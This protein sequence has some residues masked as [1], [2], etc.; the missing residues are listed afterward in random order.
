MREEDRYLQ[1]RGG[2]WHYVR[3]VPIDVAHHYSDASCTIRKSLKTDD[4]AEAR[5]RRDALEE[6][7]NA[8]WVSLRLDGKASDATERRYEAAVK[9]A[10]A[11]S[12]RY[13]P[14]SDLLPGA[15]INQLIERLKVI[16]GEK[17]AE[18]AVNTALLG[19]LDRPPVTLQDA[20]QVI[21]DE[22]H[23][24]YLNA[25]DEEGRTDWL[26]GKQRSID[27]F[28]SLYGDKPIDEIDRE[29]AR[30]FFN[31]WKERITKGDET[32]TGGYANRHIGNLRKLLSDYWAH[33]GED[34]ENPF[35]GFSFLNKR[36]SKRRPFSEE[37]IKALFLK[38][39]KFCDLNREARF[40]ILMMVETGARLSE[41]ATLRKQD[42]ILDHDYPHV[43]IE[44][45]DGRSVKTDNSNRIMPLVG[46]ALEVAKVVAN[47]DGFPHY[48]TRRK[49]LSSTV[50]KF[51]RDHKFFPA[52]SGKSAYS[53][54]HSYEDRMKEA[55]IDV[56]MRKYLLGHSIDRQEYGEYA[57]IKK[58]WQIAKKLE[59]P[60][61]G[62]VLAV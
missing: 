41:L 46:V 26:K 17:G 40:I 47:E 11:L 62:A 56:E 8:Y 5:I 45:R 25:K 1:L 55:D 4:L 21:C 30:K 18:R 50:N 27:L 33:L 36:K 28:V 3:R 59:L 52:D 35:D 48:R 9:R 39:G 58:K 60:F 34:H 15:E 57:S 43:L 37:E 6:A 54:R 42:F 53:L 14:A 19:R 49:T 23:A 10:A 32:V 24:D 16:G 2:R 29:T 44:E 61:D 38:P 12:Y 20:F 13:A 7:D 31:Y 22:V 51:F